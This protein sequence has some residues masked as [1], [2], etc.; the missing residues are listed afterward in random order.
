MNK[1]STVFGLSKGG[2][3]EGDGNL[4]S[5]VP[6]RADASGRV[7]LLRLG[8]RCGKCTGVRGEQRLRK[9][10]SFAVPTAR[11]AHAAAI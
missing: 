10:F 9:C 11:A 2:L 6:A 1:K 5:D 7:A 4:A 3:P 8:G